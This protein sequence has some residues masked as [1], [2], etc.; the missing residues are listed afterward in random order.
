MKELQAHDKLN[1]RI[2]IAAKKNNHQETTL[3]LTGTLAPK[4]GHTLWEIHEATMVIKEAKFNANKD[5]SFHKAVQKDY[6]GIND[7]IINEGCVYIPALN[8]Q[9]AL[10]LYRQNQ[11]QSAYYKKKALMKLNE[12]FF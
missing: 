4:K 10:R 1:D 8:K 6:S 12:T 7:L 5:I 3:L 11:N 9:N 2:Q